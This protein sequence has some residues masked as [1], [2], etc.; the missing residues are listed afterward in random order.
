MCVLH[1][2]HDPFNRRFRKANKRLQ[3]PISQT[4]LEPATL[5]IQSWET[6][7]STRIDVIK[8]TP[9]TNI[10]YTHMHKASYSVGK[11]GTLLGGK[12]AGACSSPFTSTKCLI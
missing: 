4:G 7:V 2:E 12:A 6:N 10:C 11:G 9:M 3:T 1:K 5:N 8:C